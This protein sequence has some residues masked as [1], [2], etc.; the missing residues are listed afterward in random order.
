[1]K[2]R[3]M[4][5]LALSATIVGLSACERVSKKEDPLA[6]NIIDEA[7]LSG[8]MLTA[9]DPSSAA[10][11]FEQA[12]AKEPN[13]ADYRRG[14]AISYTRAKRYAEAARVYQEMITLGQAESADRLD[15]AFVAIRLD[16]WDDVKALARSFP[17]GLQT[18]RRYMIDAMVADQDEDWAAADAAYAR[19]EKLSTRPAAVLNN[20][21]VSQ[22]SRGDLEAAEATFR[23]SISFDSSLFSAKNNLAIVRGLQGQYELP[24]VPLEGD[25]RAVLMN[26]LGIIAMRRGDERTARNL[27]AAAV[28]TSPQ[29]YSGAADRLAALEADTLN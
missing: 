20:W 9:A 1:M 29:H 28:A 18:P 13:R 2:S 4:L 11:Y 6:E 10:E 25:E 22:M 5:W 3:M 8:L 23:R 16:L 15:Y 14:L 26:N 24:L 19:A 27:F 12:S 17:D 7:D 21:G